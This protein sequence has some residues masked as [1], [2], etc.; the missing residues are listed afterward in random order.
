M[1]AS[2]TF[3]YLS[4]QVLHP[5]SPSTP[6]LAQILASAVATLIQVGCRACP[7]PLSI[8]FIAQIRV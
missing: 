8:T 5:T 4:R 3:D 2:E 1:K 6:V 7:V